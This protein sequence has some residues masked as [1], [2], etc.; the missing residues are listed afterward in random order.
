LFSFFERVVVTNARNDVGGD[1]VHELISS[2]GD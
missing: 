1:R 2:S